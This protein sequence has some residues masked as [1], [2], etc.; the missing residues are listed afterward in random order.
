MPTSSD[1]DNRAFPRAEI[2]LRVEYAKPELLASDY[3]R[4]VS[5]GGIFVRT[6]YPL[7]VGTQFLLRLRVPGELEG[8]GKGSGAESEAEAGFESKSQ[9]SSDGGSDL[10]QKTA[11]GL[12]AARE[13]PLRCEVSWVRYAG[14]DVVDSEVGMGVRF[15]FADEAQRLD[16]E[17]YVEALGLVD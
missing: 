14:P 3:T 10:S 16:F 9:A 7:P 1:G 4:N 11:S 8:A 12:G 2:E 13:F 15:L 6:P 5:R 17:G